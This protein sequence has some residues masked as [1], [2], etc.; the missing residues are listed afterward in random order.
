VEP[1]VLV[2]VQFAQ[3]D[4]L[5][6]QNPHQEASAALRHVASVVLHGLR[7]YHGLGRTP[8]EAL[9]RLRLFMG[10]EHV[11]GMIFCTSW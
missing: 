6:P 4:P 7:Q 11:P 9:E 2:G 3:R 10:G 1:L 8:E 5:D